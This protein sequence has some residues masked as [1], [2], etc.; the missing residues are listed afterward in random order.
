[1]IIARKSSR[2]SAGWKIELNFTINLHKKDV[3]LLKDI[4]KFFGDIGRISKERNGCCDFTVSSLDQIVKVIIPHFDKY[5][6]IT[7]KLA[8]YILFKKTAIMMKKGEHLTSEGLKAII[9]IRA[10]SNRGL[11]PALK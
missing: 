3:K 5:S 8:D 9:N 6:L 11:T 7:Q 10:S 1:M 2:S 4:Q